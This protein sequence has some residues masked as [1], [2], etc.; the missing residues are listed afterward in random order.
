MSYN[1]FGYGLMIADRVRLDAYVKALRQAV[2]PDSVVLDIGTGTGIFALL[3]CRFGAR[4]VYAIEPDD[5]IQV[6]REIA[7]A[8]GYAERIEFFQTLSTQVTL[9]EQAD[10]II[11][12][13]RGVLPFSENHIPAIVDARRRLL[14][15]GGTLIPQQDTLWVAVA[16]APQLYSRYTTPWNDTY[17]L[18]LQ[19]AR[20]IATNLWIKERVTPEQL[21]VKPQCWAT[22]DYATTEARSICAEIT[23]SVARTGTGHGLSVWFDAILAEGIHFSNAP[24]EPELIYGNAFFPWSK[25]VALTAGDTVS[26]VLQADLVGEGYIWRWDTSVMNQGNPE[27]IKARFKQSSFFGAALS[28]TQLRKRAGGYIPTLNESG[29]VDRLIL[30]LMTTG[31]SLDDIARSISDRF[32]ARF[33][34]WQDALAR[35]SG[36]S[37]KYSR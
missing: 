9:P 37:E 36:L 31:I 20:K 16:E 29:Q 12:D 13:L 17:A 5:A 8:N 22:L 33:A 28:P 32:P 35:V 27:Q 7:Q 2:K 6:A 18:D 10:V 30:E 23:W 11:S 14:A 25:P 15:P 3:A 26:V 1:I 19:A 21:L 4:L 34:K 24:G